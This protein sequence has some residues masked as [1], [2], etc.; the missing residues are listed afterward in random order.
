MSQLKPRSIE[1]L[2]KFALERRFTQSK[3][4]RKLIDRR[5][6]IKQIFELDEKY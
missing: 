6:E 1:E 3:R 5:K 2:Q 4:L